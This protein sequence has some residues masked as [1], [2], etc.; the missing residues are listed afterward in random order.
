MSCLS[1]GCQSNLNSES[2]NDVQKLGIICMRFRQHQNKLKS[3]RGTFQART[4]EA[5]CN[6]IH[7]KVAETSNFEQFSPEGKSRGRRE[8]V[9]D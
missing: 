8:D 9:G 2:G 3:G 1:S 4:P 6:L 5:N 7:V